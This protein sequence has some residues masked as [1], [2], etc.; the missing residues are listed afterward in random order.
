[1]EPLSNHRPDTV[2]RPIRLERVAE[3]VANQLEKAI[4]NGVFKAGN[5][6]PS[7]WELAEQMGVSLT[8]VREAIQQLEL[9]GI[10]DTVHREDLSLGT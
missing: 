4:S 9:L 6:L 7:G 3:K 8:S 10:V 5:H 1:M 2:F